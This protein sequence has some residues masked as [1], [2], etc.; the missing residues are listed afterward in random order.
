MQVNE[1]VVNG[2]TELSLVNDTVSE[3]T[4]LEGET[5]HDASGKQITGKVVVTPVDS[6][7]NAES[8]NAIQN[9]AVAKALTK[10]LDKNPTTFQTQ[11]GKVLLTENSEGGN[12]R[13]TSPDGTLYMEQDCHNNNTFRCYVV[14]DGATKAVWYYDSV[15]NIFSLYPKLNAVNTPI[16]TIYTGTLPLTTGSVQTVTL[17]A[18][19]KFVLCYGSTDADGLK[20]WF[21]KSTSG[22]HANI[23]LTNT[24]FTFTHVSNAYPTEYYIA[25]A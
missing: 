14:K 4:L 13:L 8:E 22:G 23:T 10:K 15:N 17:G 6:E 5:A 19:P 12:L 1:V 21:A 2:V 18:K 24:G 7:L 3:D 20:K 11:N 16:P 25:L 9:K